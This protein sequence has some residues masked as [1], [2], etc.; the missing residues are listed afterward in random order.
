M[1]S[2]KD[3]LTRLIEDV[4]AAAAGSTCQYF[5]E[6][7]GGVCGE[8]CPAY[9][10]CRPCVLDM[11]EDAA[12]RL[13]A[14]MPHDMDGREIRPGD[15]VKN[16]A[17]MRIDVTDVMPLPV[18]AVDDDGTSLVARGLP[19]LW[20]VVQPDSWE[21]LETDAQLGRCE[22][23]GRQDTRTCAG[24]RARGASGSCKGEEERLRDLVR[25][26]KALAGVE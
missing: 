2:D 22:Y 16:D 13:H 25:R 5:R 20:H 21:R 3:S 14:L 17:G 8:S 9:G 4:D 1:Q 23:F 18:F 12:R 11:L 26:A 24:C 15:T 7:S 6:A 10:T 19:R